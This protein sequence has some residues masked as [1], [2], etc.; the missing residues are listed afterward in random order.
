MQCTSRLF[1]LFNEKKQCFSE[2]KLQPVVLDRAMYV[3]ILINF[4]IPLP[5][6]MFKGNTEGNLPFPNDMYLMIIFVNIQE[7]PQNCIRSY[8]NR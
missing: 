5:P 6:K 1:I 7:C 2:L 4:S 3:Y 8:T